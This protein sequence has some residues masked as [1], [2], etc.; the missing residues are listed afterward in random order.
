MDQLDFTGG[1]LT[2]T[3]DE[4]DIQVVLATKQSWQYGT[5]EITMMPSTASGIVSPAI[6]KGGD[7]SDEIDLEV[8]NENILQPSLYSHSNSD[9]QLVGGN[10]QSVQNVRARYTVAQSNFELKQGD[11]MLKKNI[12]RLATGS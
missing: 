12:G 11:A 6:F 7:K 10:P 4:N 5:F 1:V 8:L 3:V 2:M 9:F